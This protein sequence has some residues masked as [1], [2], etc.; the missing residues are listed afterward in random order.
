MKA[1]GITFLSI[2]GKSKFLSNVFTQKS[3][4]NIA[5]LTS[6]IFVMGKF[7]Q[8]EYQKRSEWRE[9]IHLRAI[10]THRILASLSTHGLMNGRYP[11]KVSTVFIDPKMM[12]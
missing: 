6:P 12:T 4:Q 7:W 3:F 9:Q 5:V 10:E 2:F 8:H 11:E 1:N